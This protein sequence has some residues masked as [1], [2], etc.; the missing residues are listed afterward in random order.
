MRHIIFSPAP[1]TRPDYPSDQTNACVV[2]PQCSHQRWTGVVCV[3]VWRRGG[4]SQLYSGVIR[5]GGEKKRK[6]E[7]EIL[8]SVPARK[9]QLCSGGITFRRPL[10]DSLCREQSAALLLR[11][12]TQNPIDLCVCREISSTLLLRDP[13]EIIICVC[14]EQPSVTLHLRDQT[15]TKDAR[16][17]NRLKL[18]SCGIRLEELCM[19]RQSL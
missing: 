18:Y 16:V 15:K 19:C 2:R 4:G 12:Q 9:I 13:S 6:K 3:Y 7:N 8:S 17:E 14:Y 5:L 1:V 11:D 10:C